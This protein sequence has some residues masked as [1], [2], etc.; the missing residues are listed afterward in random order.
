MCIK[1]FRYKINVYTF[2]QPGYC[3][4]KYTYLFHEIHKYIVKEHV[5]LLCRYYFIILWGN[6][7]TIIINVNNISW[8]L[9]YVV[10]K[11]LVQFTMNRDINSLISNKNRKQWSRRMHVDVSQHKF[12]APFMFS[13]F[14][15]KSIH[16][17]NY[18]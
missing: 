14:V 18:F 4:K 10:Y 9:V 6:W 13:N 5:M 12:S 17:F 11:V 7:K 3:R 2:S 15:K 8:S 1:C 16:E